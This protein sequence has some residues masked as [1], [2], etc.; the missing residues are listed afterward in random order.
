ME[1]HVL[2][3]RERQH[4]LE[5][6]GFR[7]Q[8]IRHYGGALKTLIICAA[9]FM[10]AVRV[11]G[12]GSV[13]DF[14]AKGDGVT[15]DTAAIQLAMNTAINVGGII[16]IPGTCN[17]YKTSATIT[18]PPGLTVIGDG[19]RDSWAELG[20][21]GVCGA[22]GGPQSRIFTTVTN[23]PVMSVIQTTPQD[24]RTTEVN[25]QGLILDCQAKAGS[26]GIQIGGMTS[27]AYT[28]FVKLTDVWGYNCAQTSV[29]VREAW[30]LKFYDV[31]TSGQG[32]G[33][34][35]DPITAT[36]AVLIKGGNFGPST[37]GHGIRIGGG[38]GSNHANIEIDGVIAEGNSLSQIFVEHTV[39]TLSIHDSYIDASATGTAIDL[40]GNVVATGGIFGTIL[41]GPVRITNN[42][43]GG[44]T[45]IYSS[46]ALLGGLSVSGNQSTGAGFLNIASGSRGVELG[47]NV[48][49]GGTIQSN[50]STLSQPG[51][52]GCKPNSANPTV[53][54]CTNTAFTEL[55]YQ[56]W[57]IMTFV[58]DVNSGVHPTLNMDGLGPVN[59]YGMDGVT[60]ITT[61]TL[62]G[63]TAY[64]MFYDTVNFRVG[65]APVIGGLTLPISIKTASYTF[66]PTDYAVDGDAS[67]GSFTVNLE[68]SPQVGQVHVLSKATAGNTL[69]LSGNGKTINGAQ[70]LFMTVQ[71]VS[72]TVQFNGNEWR[73]Q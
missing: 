48:T 45:A 58:P 8:S 18:V 28:T 27:G 59:L 60:Q 36:S 67:G 72:Y 16:Y 66:L 54:T 17:G 3:E 37:G 56:P 71:Y 43:L 64:L 47:P 10:I 20:V 11:D 30:N 51:P 6:P 55:S 33:L 69:T 13:I 42:L 19:N 7:G 32:D 41:A 53:Y 25:I 38:S 40:S 34:Y 44:G 21:A 31:R 5:F 26:I 1:L 73:I 15:D 70:N 62:I 46:T 39:Q 35:L 50:G 57:K 61:N 4:R 9:L 29:L 22:N 2:Y 68:A 52:V 24:G 14:G 63:G 23:I 12:I 65:V 49:N